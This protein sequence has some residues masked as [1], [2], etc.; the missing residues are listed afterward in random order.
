MNKPIGVHR[1]T[2]VTAVALAVSSLLLLPAAEA[3]GIVSSIVKA[4]IVPDGDVAGRPTDVVVNLEG[5]L[6]PSVPGRALLAGRSIRI[7]LPDGFVDLG[8]SIGLPAT[9]PAPDPCNTGVLLQG[10]P[11]NPI[12]PIPANYTLSIEDPNTIVY[13]AARDLVPGDPTLNGPG[14][15]QM[16]MILKGFVN[17]KPG[18]YPVRVEA[19][20]GPGGAL[21]TGVGSLHILP[22]PRASINVTSVFAGAPP[23]PNTIFQQT[24][25]GQSIPIP[26][27]FLM[28]NKRGLPAVGVE[29][30]QVNSRHAQ[31]VNGRKVVGQ[32]FIDAPH[33]A[34]G[35]QVMDGG[36]STLI[37][38]P[39]LGAPTGRLIVDFV[40]GDR[41]GTYVITLQ[42]NNGNSVD[43]QVDVN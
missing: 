37:N 15:K 23:F 14:I 19:E 22:R 20:T 17:P 6:D 8:N 38:A 42:M 36:P 34:R 26:W 28:W 16:H 24:A 27:N 7:A 31:L 39:V 35:Q 29:I 33:G 18:V 10:W 11:Q 21:E 9:C 1:S 5:S 2:F 3:G 43:M 13:T 25:P 30:R 41:P 40:A 32:I 4:P 12:R